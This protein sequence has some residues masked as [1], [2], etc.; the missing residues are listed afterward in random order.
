LSLQKFRSPPYFHDIQREFP[1]RAELLGFRN[2]TDQR[3]Q[4]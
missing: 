4:A 1:E 2:I 3:E